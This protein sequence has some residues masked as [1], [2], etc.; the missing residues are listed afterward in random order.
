MSKGDIFLVDDNANNLTLLYGI[1]RNAG[2]QVR[3]A[4]NGRRALETV[5][6][7]PPELLMLDINMPEMNGYEVCEQLKANPITRD[8]P[9]IFISALDDVFDKVR[10]FRV[11][12]IDYVPKPFQAE[13]VLARVETQLN[14]FRL[15]RD[16]E[17]K[18]IE[19]ERKQRE[20][21]ASNKELERQNVE[22]E[23]KNDELVRAQARTNLIFSAL[24]DVLPGTMLDEKYRLE[25]KIGAGGFGAVFKATHLTLNRPVAIKV[26]RPSP[27]ND[28][29][30]AVERFRQE[31]L[32]ASRLSHPNAVMV[33]DFG[34]STAGI[35]YLVMELLEG[36]TL[37]EVLQE[38][39]V[40]PVSRCVEILVP[41]CEALAEAHAAN[42]VHRDVKP[43][44]IFLH[45]G[46]HGEVIKVVD[47]GIAKLFAHAEAPEMQ[48]MTETGVI[49][50]TPDYMAPERL[51]GG[52]YDGRSDVYSV[53]VLLFQ[54]IT[55]KFPFKLDREAGPYAIA[56]KL[57]TEEPRPV[58]EFAPDVPA[59]IERLVTQA[60][61]KDPAER[62]TAREFARDL[63]ALVRAAGQD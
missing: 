31:A 32:S 36:R 50:G 60:L 14:L 52:R 3:A 11:G 48:G 43:D 29:P 15:R 59:E 4:N 9:V 57:M 21:E 62:P 24:S 22:L 10:A 25:E 53:G 20:L 6:A 17:S 38:Q 18:R 51:S 8:I 28:S 23:R 33:I 13:E 5:S 2:Y 39:S 49:L 27:G 56:L 16:L 41:V 61:A 1:L 58:R 34:V 37:K 7:Y 45:E 40:L 54:M 63:A 47:F 42:V 30:E 19:L 35:A 44:N 26:L 55:G 12:G 46:E